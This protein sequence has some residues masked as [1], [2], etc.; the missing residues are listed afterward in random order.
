MNINL[1]VYLSKFKCRYVSANELK[2]KNAPQVSQNATLY[3]E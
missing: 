2:N 1:K 3:L